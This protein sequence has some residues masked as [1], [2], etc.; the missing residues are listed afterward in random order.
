MH[1][2]CSQGMLGQPGSAFQ[3]GQVDMYAAIANGESMQTD[4][5]AEQACTAAL[6]NKVHLA[7]VDIQNMKCMVQNV[8]EAVKLC[9]NIKMSNASANLV[10][11]GSAIKDK[12]KK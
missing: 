10:A 9:K 12:P 3:I 5:E 6:E 11:L 1:E 4:I 8:A 2:N 7:N